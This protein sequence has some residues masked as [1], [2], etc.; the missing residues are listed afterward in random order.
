M[1]QGHIL[2]VDDEKNI[3]LVIAQCLEAAGY[4]VDLAVDGEHGLQKM[5]EHSYHLLLLD[6]KLPGID[7]MEVLTQSRRMH[8]DLPV[9]MMTAHGTVE[10]AVEAMK[11]GAL[12]Y[13]Q[14]PF[15]PDEILAQVS[16]VL[17]RQD[18]PLQAP[19]AGFDRCLD[20]AKQLIQQR[21][22]TQAAAFLRK[23]LTLETLRPEPYNLLGCIEELQGNEPEA[24]RLYRA[25]LAVVPSYA[26]ALGN[27]HRLVQMFRHDGQG[28]DL[29][30]SKEDA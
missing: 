24:Q 15:T 26:P 10:T 19:A 16:R 4:T 9:I 22:F 7:G 20:Q 17:G 6:L 28:P 12:D 11:L 27:L 2:V 30:E 1:P 13:L 25:A 5:A 23:A 18:L 29:G 8:A 3:R 21:N 14:K